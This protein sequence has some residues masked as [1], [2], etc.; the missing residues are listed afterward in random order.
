MSACLVAVMTVWA[1][2]SPFSPLSQQSTV[3]TD[4]KP[5]SMLEKVK[6]VFAMSDSVLPSP[7]KEPVAYQ[8][9]SES[10]PAFSA[11][12][13]GVYAE[14]DTNELTQLEKTHALQQQDRTA[15]L[16]FRRQGSMLVTKPIV[17][18]VELPSRKDVAME[19]TDLPEVH[20]A[21]ADPRP[22]QLQIDQPELETIPKLPTQLSAAVDKSSVKEKE[23]PARIATRNIGSYSSLSLDKIFD[24]AAQPTLIG[25]EPSPARVA[26]KEPSAPVAKEQ[27]P[28]RVA[29]LSDSFPYI[30]PFGN[31]NTTTVLPIVPTQPLP[32]QRSWETGLY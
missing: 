21:S 12:I 14:P 3:E 29:T 5:V 7:T 11:T 20:F 17:A 27:P 25:T 23:P 16:S 9:Q 6:D 22:M 10:P 32:Q 31:Q 13:T 1:T 8:L 18:A 24:K 15:W 19:T 26:Q 30:A 28:A 4:Y 2:S